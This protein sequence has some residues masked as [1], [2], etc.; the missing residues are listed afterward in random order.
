MDYGPHPGSSPCVHFS[1]VCLAGC[2]FQIVRVPRNDWIHALVDGKNTLLRPLLAL[3]LLLLTLSA[4]LQALPQ[5]RHAFVYG[6]QALAHSIQALV[7]VKQTLAEGPEALPKMVQEGF[8]LLHA[9]VLCMQQGIGGLHTLFLL[10]RALF[11]HLLA[12][13]R[14]LK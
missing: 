9:V 6:L 4:K 12:L 13:L 10:L 7:Q 5:Y 8:A 11:L 14:G 1:A 3:L 2:G